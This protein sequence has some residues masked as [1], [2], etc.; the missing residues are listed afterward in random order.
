MNKKVIVKDGVNTRT[1]ELI[2]NNGDYFSGFVFGRTEKLDK[3][4]G[5]MWNIVLINKSSGERYNFLFASQMTIGRIP[6]SDER[7]TRLVLSTDV[8]VSKVHAIIYGTDNTL[9]I[10]DNQSKNHTY[11]NGERITMPHVLNPGDVI[12]VGRT[13]FQVTYGIS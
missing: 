5:R 8:M 6:P 10:A 2:I 13:E 9:A 1:G 11:V 7:E 12:R 3:H 4:S